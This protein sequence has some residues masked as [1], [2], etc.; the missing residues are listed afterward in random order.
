[1]CL[2]DRYIS[3]GVNVRELSP[4][5]APEIPPDLRHFH[6][7][8]ILRPSSFHAVEVSGPR[9]GGRALIP[10]NAVLFFARVGLPFAS[11]FVFIDLARPFYFLVSTFCFFWMAGRLSVQYSRHQRTAPFRLCTRQLPKRET[12]QVLR[13]RRV[14]HGDPA[15]SKQGSVAP[16]A[17]QN[18]H[19]RRLP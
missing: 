12:R 2:Y 14:G 5:R 3:I 8:M 7:T 9:A 4:I 10:K 16:C 18:A 11:R 13:F 19:V 6:L 17:G 15:G 1:M